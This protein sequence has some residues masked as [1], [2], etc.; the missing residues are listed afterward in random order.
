MG[1]ND[2]AMACAAFWIDVAELGIGI[3]MLVES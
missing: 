1:V 2:H 3:A